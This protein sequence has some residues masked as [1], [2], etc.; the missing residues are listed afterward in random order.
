MGRTEGQWR[1]G[2]KERDRDGEGLVAE[3]LHGRKLM[4]KRKY[5]KNYHVNE[6]VFIK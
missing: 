5:P 1:K 2:G 3:S 6:I 4:N